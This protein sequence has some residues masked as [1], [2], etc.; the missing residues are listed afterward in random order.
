[1]SRKMDAF[2]AD[3][4][5]LDTINK[6]ATEL[7]RELSAIEKEQKLIKNEVIRNMGKSTV[8]SV[9]G[10]DVFE[11]VPTSRKSVTLDNVYTYAPKDLW[12]L[13]INDNEGLN[14]KFLQVAIK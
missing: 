9:G 4:I 10:V 13:L 6:R 2:A 1:M 14:V 7:R 8:G 11:V 3:L 12:P 5:R